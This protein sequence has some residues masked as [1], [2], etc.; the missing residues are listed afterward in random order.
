ML[1]ADKYISG[2]GSLQ[3]KL[4]S[5]IYFARYFY[6]PLT[7]SII[8]HPD[9]IKSCLIFSLFTVNGLEILSSKNGE[10]ENSL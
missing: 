9:E 5:S 8:T 1:Q 10:W 2:S 7:I 3:F 4:Y 6:N